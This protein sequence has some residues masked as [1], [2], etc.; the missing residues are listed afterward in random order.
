MTISRAWRKPL[1]KW[2]YE[3][4]RVEDLEQAVRRAVKVCLTPPTGPV[5]LSLP[6]DVMLAPL[7][8]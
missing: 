5:F 3:V 7:R 4:R 6:G 1:V 8:I 2:A